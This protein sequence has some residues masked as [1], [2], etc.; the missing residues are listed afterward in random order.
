MW[1]DEKNEQELSQKCF[2]NCFFFFFAVPL[3][4]SRHRHHGHWSDLPNL[5]PFASRKWQWVLKSSLFVSA[6]ILWGV[7]HPRQSVRTHAEQLNALVPHGC[8]EF[9]VVGDG[10]DPASSYE[11]RTAEDSTVNCVQA[12]RLEKWHQWPMWGLIRAWIKA[13]RI[14]KRNCWVLWKRDT[15]KG[16]MKA[17]LSCQKGEWS[18]R[19][20]RWW[21]LKTE[22]QFWERMLR[23]LFQVYVS[24]HPFVALHV[25]L[26]LLSWICASGRQH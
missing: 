12:E 20:M 9:E 17:G 3:S 22:R 11:C 8:L 23:Y 4:L 21:R 14:R 26:L 1:C 13:C 24:A 5:L 15:M 10:S 2:L 6:F 25:Y 7:S 18:G 19:V 16:Q